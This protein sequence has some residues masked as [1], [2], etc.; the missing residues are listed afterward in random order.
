[1][2]FT[3][4]CRALVLQ[5]ELDLAAELMTL[6]NAV[7]HLEAQNTTSPESASADANFLALISRSA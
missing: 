5:R 7:L 3:V 1:M 2:L 4:E 6:S